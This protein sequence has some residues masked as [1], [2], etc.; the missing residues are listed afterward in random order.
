VVSFLYLLQSYHILVHKTIHTR[1]TLSSPSKRNIPS[2]SLPYT[3]FYRTRHP[4]YLSFIPTTRTR[5]HM[6]VSHLILTPP[7]TNDPNP[8]SLLCFSS[9]PPP[10]SP[11]V[12]APSPTP[13]RRSPRAGGGRRAWRAWRAGAAAGHP[14]R[15]RRRRALRARHL[16]APRRRQPRLPL[17]H[18]GGSPS[19]LL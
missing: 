4:L 17:L 16:L 3:T 7:P 11:C 13:S 2:Y 8:F 12:H 6:S 15:V 9:A 1:H 5:T 10:S 14:P 19:P 18:G